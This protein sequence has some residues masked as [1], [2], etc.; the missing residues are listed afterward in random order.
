LAAPLSD[1]RA[2][3]AR[4]EES[5]F[6]GTRVAQQ[7]EEALKRAD[8]RAAEEGQLARVHAR[9]VLTQ[10]RR[11]PGRARAG[12]VAACSAAAGRVQAAAGAPCSHDCFW[13][14]RAVEL[15][16]SSAPELAPL[17]G[18]AR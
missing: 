6:K 4:K 3:A 16:W 13:A 18:S 7:R 14:H 5:A 8:V 11:D 12:D 15:V 17:V 9:N 10:Q 2:R 1:R